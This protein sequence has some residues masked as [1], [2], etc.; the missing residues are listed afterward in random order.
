MATAIRCATC[1]KT[2]EVCAYCEEPECR[3]VICHECLNVALAQSK[4]QPHPH[5]G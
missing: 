2:V 5:G 4:P 3:H 1:G